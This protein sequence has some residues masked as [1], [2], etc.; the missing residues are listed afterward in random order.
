MY[1]KYILL[2]VSS[3]TCGADPSEELSPQTTQWLTETSLSPSSFQTATG[4][5]CVLVAQLLI[6]IHFLI[7]LTK[8]NNSFLTSPLLA[9]ST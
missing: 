1:R 8:Q 5:L 9:F 4:I 6:F 7:F 3:Q 2:I